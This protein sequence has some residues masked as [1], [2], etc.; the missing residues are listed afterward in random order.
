MGI[1]GP[2]RWIVK[3]N[4][5]RF[6]K[7]QKWPFTQTEFKILN[8]LVSLAMSSSDGGFQDIW[9]LGTVSFSWVRHGYWVCSIYTT[10]CSSWVSEIGV[11]SEITSDGD[12]ALEEGN[13]LG[14]ERDASWEWWVSGDDCY[15]VTEKALVVEDGQQTALLRIFLLTF[16][17]QPLPAGTIVGNELCR[18]FGCSFRFI[19]NFIID[20]VRQNT[21]N[22]FSDFPVA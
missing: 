11:R 9:T 3:F 7:W 13:S 5:R 17:E 8:Q 12:A 14:L 6:R 10:S 20:K 22:E 1:G 15:P 16:Q 2:V 4:R 21:C 18:R 19:Q